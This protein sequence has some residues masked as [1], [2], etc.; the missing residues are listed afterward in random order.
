MCLCLCFYVCIF[1]LLMRQMLAAV[2]VAWISLDLKINKTF[3]VD[4]QIY[5]IVLPLDHLE[6]VFF[7]YRSVSICFMCRQHGNSL[8]TKT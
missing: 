5:S 2:L 3:K 1:A 7:T 6:A 4:V 8:S